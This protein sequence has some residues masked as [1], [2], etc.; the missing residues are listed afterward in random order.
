MTKRIYERS[1]R[2]TAP[3]ET[4]L[5]ERVQT[6]LTT[7]QRDDFN[8]VIGDKAEVWMIRKVITDYTDTHKPLT[9]GNALLDQSRLALAG[10]MIRSA[11]W[12]KLNLSVAVAIIR[13][14]HEGGALEDSQ[15]YDWLFD[16]D[17]QSMRTRE[18]IAKF[19]Y[20]AEKEV[21]G[22]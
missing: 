5:G 11:N 13:L 3:E 14:L 16:E 15:I 7:K 1:G 18:G 4:K 22:E 12:Q 9:T 21:F 6:R 10:E 2:P 17:M 20:Q 8:E 19:R